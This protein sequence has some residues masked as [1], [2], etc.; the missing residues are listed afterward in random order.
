LGLKGGGRVRL[1]TLPPSV[2]RLSRENVGASTSRN[3]VGLSR[4]VTGIPLPLN[5]N[6]AH[7]S[8]VV[9]VKG[10]VH[11]WQNDAVCFKAHAWLSRNETAV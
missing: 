10:S 9:R 4:P 11:I 2:S 7:C 6:Q 3:P 5:Q 8:D 1:T